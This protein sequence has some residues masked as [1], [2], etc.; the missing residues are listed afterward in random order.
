[1]ERQEDIRPVVYVLCGL[2]GAGKSTWAANHRTET[3]VSLDEV[4]ARFGPYSRDVEPYVNQVALATMLAHL[5][6]GR[7]VVYDA[8]NR[9]RKHRKTIIDAAKEAGFGAWIVWVKCLLETSLQRR[10]GEIPPERLRELAKQF[11]PPV[12]SDEEA[13]IL[14]IDGEDGAI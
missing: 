9:T 14:E 10:S 4:R 13:M 2:P 6:A 12:Y 7:D 8:T 5:A 11:E 3:V 1:M